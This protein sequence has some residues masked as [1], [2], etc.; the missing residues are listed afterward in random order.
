MAGGTEDA[1]QA[2]DWD[3]QRYNANAGFVA[4][5]GRR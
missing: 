5:S 3:P 4:D 2:Q 1:G